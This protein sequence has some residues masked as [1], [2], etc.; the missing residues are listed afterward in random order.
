MKLNIIQKWD[1]DI[2]YLINKHCK[3]K[4]LD[5]VMPFVTTL[6]DLGMIW[7]ILAV[8]MIGKADYRKTGVTV[9]VTLVFTTIMGEGILKHIVKRKR[10]FIGKENKELLIKEPSSFSFP[11]GHTSSSFAVAVVFL[12]S[13]SNISTII[14][15]IALAIAFSRMYLKVHYPSDIVGGM[16]LG[17][18]CGGIIFNYLH[19]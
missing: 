11:S 1:E 5:K 19:I 3:S 17:T 8:L 2:L 6:G 12:R 18:I 4:F 15:L 13:N 7:I 10:P 16:I 14:V 9:L